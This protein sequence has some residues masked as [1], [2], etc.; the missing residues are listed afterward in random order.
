MGK[1]KEAQFYKKLKNSQVQCN[2]CPRFCVIKLGSR[3]NCGVR[4]NVDGKLYSLV[5][6]RPCSIALDPIEKKPLYHFFP[7]Q[8]AL[9]VATVGCNLHCLYCQ[10]WEISQCQPEKAASFK[11]SPERVIEEA[12]NRKVKIMSYTYTEPTIF[13]EYMFDIAKLAKKKAIKN[14]TITN[15]FINPEPL[16]QLC[17]FLDASNIDFKGSDNFYKK[18]SGAWRKPVEEA[19]KIMHNKGVWLELTTLIIAGHNDKEKDIKEI[20][21]WIKKNLSADVPLHFSAFYPSYKMLDVPATS[22]ETIKKARR[23]ALKYLNY[24]YT[25]NIIDEEGSTTLCPSCKK[26]VIVRKGFSIKEN[27]LVK[28]KCPYCNEKIAGVF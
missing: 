28:G 25:G 6:G 19:L 21:M 2:L 18:L 9:S 23:L 17:N 5:Y 22:A 24:V 13:Y 4:E 20:V 8:Q 7:G 12:I 11:M 3:G 26:S 16:T 27:K 1:M 10:N 14:T 15:A